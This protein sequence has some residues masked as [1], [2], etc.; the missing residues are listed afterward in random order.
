MDKEEVEPEQFSNEYSL[1]KLIVFV[2]GSGAGPGK[3]VIADVSIN[4]LDALRSELAIQQLKL[5]NGGI[6]IPLRKNDRPRDAQMTLL[7]LLN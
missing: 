3:S 4:Q 5:I 1:K 2:R 6:L 7:K